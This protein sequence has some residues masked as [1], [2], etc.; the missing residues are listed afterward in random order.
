[1]AQKRPLKKLESLIWGAQELTGEFGSSFFL[2]KY[3]PLIKTYLCKDKNDLCLFRQT[4]PYGLRSPSLT[5]LN[6]YKQQDL[7][8]IAFGLSIQQ[9]WV[10]ITALLKLI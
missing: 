2:P 6:N 1:M 8:W 9:N 7:G 5:Q 4:Q 10:R 3:G